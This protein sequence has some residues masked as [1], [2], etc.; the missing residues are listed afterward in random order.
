MMAAQPK[1]KEYKLTDV[2]RGSSIFDRRRGHYF[3]EAASVSLDRQQH[4][5][6][7]VFKVTGHVRTTCH[8]IRLPVDESMRRFHGDE[9]VAAEVGGYC[10]AFI[11]LRETKNLYPVEKSRTGTGF[12]YWVGDKN[13]P[14]FQGKARLEVSSIL[15]ENKHNKVKT[16]VERKKQQTRQ[17]DG[18]GLPAYVVVVEYSKLVVHMSKRD[19]R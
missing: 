6:S 10:L 18:T 7:V 9:R 17:S 12:D 2:Y 14:L 4:G 16:R 11:I 5:I 1:I 13:D 8:I 19:A 3:A 15:S